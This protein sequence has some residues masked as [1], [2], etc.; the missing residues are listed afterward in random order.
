MVGDFRQCLSGFHR[1]TACAM[2]AFSTF[3][4]IGVG[5]RVVGYLPMFRFRIRRWRKSTT[6]AT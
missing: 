5:G 3:A 2:G 1:T 4:D 6:E